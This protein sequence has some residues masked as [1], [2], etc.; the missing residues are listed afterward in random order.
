[1]PSIIVH[2]I[3]EK[4]YMCVYMHYCINIIVLFPFL[5]NA[6]KLFLCIVHFADARYSIA[7]WE[8]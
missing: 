8:E 7:K 2:T 6:Y 1:M 4:V 5:R 3:V